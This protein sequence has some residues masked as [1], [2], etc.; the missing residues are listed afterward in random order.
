MTDSTGPIFI[1]TAELDAENFAWLD[2]LRRAHFP[3]E[4]NFLS[5]HLTMFHRLSPLHIERLLAIP[6]PSGP[7]KIAF[8]GVTFL[9]FGSA[10]RATS[11]EL[12]RLREELKDGMGDGFSRQDARHWSPHV[13]VQNKV[14]PEEARDLFRTLDDKFTT[15]D[16]EV[17]GLLIW[18][19]L[20]G[21]WKLA[22]RLPFEHR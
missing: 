11:S 5:A 10:I 19:Y 6:P 21:P 4:R 18:E 15:R 3:A 1:L 14:S 16:G 7:M 8:T 17:L 12:E 9:G 13:T 22:R 20:G 2:G